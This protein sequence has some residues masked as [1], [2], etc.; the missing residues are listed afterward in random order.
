MASKHEAGR[1]EGVDRPARRA[2]ECGSPT[3]DAG[4]ER[5]GAASRAWRATPNTR[6]SRRSIIFALIG[7]SVAFAATPH[8]RADVTSSAPDSFTVKHAA[9]VPLAPDAAYARLL[10]IAD[11]WDGEHT[12]SGDAK[13]MSMAAAPGGCF[14]EKLGSGGFIEH[15]RVIYAD[16][17]NVLRMD[18]GL[19]PLQG[20]G[21][22]GVLTY[23]LKAE[24]TGTRV[25]MTYVVLGAAGSLEKVA[26]QVDVVMGAS[27]AR[28]ANVGGAV[29]AE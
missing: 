15:M 3:C 22:R 10:R 9:L 20:L 2:G 11:W 27:L 19:G 1:V 25:S 26:A 5:V 16:P 18:G 17:G 23:V 8:A 14:C 4:A 7:A 6:P 12:Y 28:F 21:A 13:N 29:R 24:G